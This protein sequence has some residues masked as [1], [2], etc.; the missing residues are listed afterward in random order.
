MLTAR[1]PRRRDVLELPPA[2]V[3]EE[4]IA[5][6]QIAEVQIREPVAVEISRAHSGA[7]EEALVGQRARVGKLVGKPDPGLLRRQE[8]KAGSSVCRNGETRHAVAR[9]RFP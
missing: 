4:P 5:A 2:Q 1:A 7:V 9:T 3:P 6:F 8:R